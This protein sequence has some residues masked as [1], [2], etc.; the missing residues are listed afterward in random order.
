M[1]CGGLETGALRRWKDVQYRA[2]GLCKA[3][4][5]ACAHAGATAPELMELGGHSDP[6]QPR[7]YLQ[8]VEQETMAAS[9]VDKLLKKQR[10]DTEWQTANTLP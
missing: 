10:R 9:A 2:H 3:A 1:R 5:L 8:E 4:L 7:Q 6:E